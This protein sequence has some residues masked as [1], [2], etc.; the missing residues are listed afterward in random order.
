MVHV[1]GNVNVDLL[2]GPLADWPQR[3][4]ETILSDREVRAGGAAGNAALALAAL[5]VPT[6]L[7]AQVGDDLLGS[8]LSREFLDRGLSLAHRPGMPTGLSVGV[9]HPGGERTFFTHLGH[10]EYFDLDPV[11][12]AFAAEPGGIVLLCGYFLL[13]SLRGADALRLVEAARRHGHRI[14]LDPGWPPEG[15]T[16]GVRA[17]FDA[18]S[19]LADVILPNEAEL[20]GWTG[21]ADVA[22]GLDAARRRTSLVVKVGVEG[23]VYMHDGTVERVLAP[24]VPVADTVGAGDAFNAGF[25]AAWW[26]GMVLPQRVEVAVRTAA[27][28][29]SSA[30]RRYPTWDEVAGGMMW[31]RADTR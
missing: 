9:V 22:A 18:I 27:R 7:H 24:Q 4:T 13:P 19:A 25:I 14:C 12:R 6:R 15:W 16:H 1:V 21:A 30:P 17:E 29:I 26:R 3:G 5:A 20:L 2:L 11:L 8:L 23:A 10:L 28:A 31:G